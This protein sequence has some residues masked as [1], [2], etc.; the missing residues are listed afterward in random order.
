MYVRVVYS[1]HRA[2]N[3]EQQSSIALIGVT[4]EYSLQFDVMQ[5]SR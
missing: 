5:K 4:P 3:T 1:L 2:G